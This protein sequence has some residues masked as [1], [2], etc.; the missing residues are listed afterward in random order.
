MFTDY[1]EIKM[2]R[3]R[4]QGPAGVTKV[5]VAQGCIGTS[6]EDPEAYD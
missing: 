6:P 5:A 1:R 4:Y 3:E 2:D